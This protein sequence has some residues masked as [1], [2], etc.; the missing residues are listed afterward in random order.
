MQTADDQ[1]KHHRIHDVGLPSHAEE[2]AKTVC[3][4]IICVAAVVAPCGPHGPRPCRHASPNTRQ[5]TLGCHAYG[6]CA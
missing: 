2:P 6:V 1:G 4:L 5:Q 3:G